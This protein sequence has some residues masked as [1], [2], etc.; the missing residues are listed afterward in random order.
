MEITAP[1]WLRSPLL[2]GPR[3]TCEDMLLTVSWCVAKDV[4][5]RARVHVGNNVNTLCSHQTDPPV[6]ANR[7]IWIQVCA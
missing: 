2:F 7:W 1:K 6:H 3:R 5:A 4:C